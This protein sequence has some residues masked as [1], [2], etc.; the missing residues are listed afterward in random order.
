MEKGLIGY[1]EYID[2][3]RIKGW[4]ISDT[5]T[6]PLHLKV[7]QDNKQITSFEAK[8]FRNGIA[9]S[10]LSTDG[11]C[12]FDHQLEV[13][14]ESTANISVRWEGKELEYSPMLRNKTDWNLEA[15]NKY[16][17]KEDELFYFIHV[18]KTAGTTF[19][20]LLEKE[21]KAS[22]TLPSQKDIIA[23][24]GR[25]PNLLTIK[26]LLDEKANQTR[27]LLAIILS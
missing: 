15:G 17:T 1:V 8:L 12:G 25:Y 19:R 26:S 6:G 21:F 27:F 20:L 22:E 7:Y 24:G 13:E 16:Q 18:P 9:K 5:V 10:K 2:H 4:A 23:N 3:K 14:L 11:Y